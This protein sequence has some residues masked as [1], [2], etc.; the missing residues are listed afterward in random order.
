MKTAIVL[1]YLLF[2]LAACNSTAPTPTVTAVPSSTS[3]QQPS[4]TFTKALPEATVQQPRP[5]STPKPTATPL[6]V[7]SLVEKG[8]LFVWDNQAK[9]YEMFDL[10]TGNLSRVIRWT[11]GCEWEML[12]HA[13]VTVCENRSGQQ[14]LLDVLKGSTQNL[15]IWN[16]RL[17]GWEPKGRFL[18][19]TQGTADSLDILSYDITANVT[20]TLA[21]DIDRQEQ[22]RWLTQPVLSADGE[23]LIVVRGISNQPNTSVFE[24]AKIGAQFRQIGLS[25][26]PAT[27]DVAWSPVANQ[28]VYGATDIEQEIGP[29][30]NYLFLV[31]IQN[32]EIREL[33]ESPQPV[34]FWSWSLEWSPTGK[35][36]AVG[37]WDL[38]FKSES[39][40]CVIDLDTVRQV[41]RPA[42]RS[43]NGKFLA[44]SPTGKHIAFV[45]TAANLVVSNPNGTE[46][47]TLV[48]NVPEDFLLVW[49]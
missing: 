40:A 38:A 1:G 9:Q 13:T 31:S 47:V 22:N 8:I 7:T 48:K 15:P 20:R 46:A 10:N 4:A 3:T 33:A 2:V 43:I 34:F 16:A 41:C 30:P 45:D 17:I 5:T 37:L 11:P 25:E 44:W 24:I 23:K 27:W 18:A 49:R 6:P 21:L 19:F 32:G 42:L 14:Y 39:L 28:F 26:L 12:P 35:Q 29:S 36:I